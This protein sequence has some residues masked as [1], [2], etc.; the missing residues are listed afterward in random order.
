MKQWRA[1]TLRKKVSEW[2]C[3]QESND[4]K[5]QNGRKKG[6]N[7]GRRVKN[8]AWSTGGT[9]ETGNEPQQ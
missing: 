4:E 9:G 1:Q 7:D 2:E 3:V 5:R 8:K 6:K